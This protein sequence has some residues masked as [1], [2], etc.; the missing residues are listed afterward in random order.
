MTLSSSTV[1]VPSWMVVTVGTAIGSLLLLLFLEKKTKRTQHRSASS[2]SINN[3]PYLQEKRQRLP[4]LILLLRHAESE[5]NADHTIFRTKPDNLVSLTEK[6]VQ[7]AIEAGQRI[8]RLFQS[9]ENEMQTAPIGLGRES[10]QK[11]NRVHIHVS[12]YERTVQTVNA[13]RQAFERRVVRTSPESRIREQEFGNYSLKDS[14]Q[15]QQEQQQVGR[16]WYR[17]PTGESG[18]DVY[19]R[20]KSW[21]CE[22]VLTVNERVGYD[23][24]DAIVVV[25]HSL[26]MRFVLMQL[27]NW[28]PFTFHSVWSAQACELYVLRKDLAIPGI[29]PYILDDIH[30]DMPRS[31]VNVHVRLKKNESVDDT[32]ECTTT[33]SSASTEIS[34]TKMFLLRDYLHLP[35]PR[36]IQT[37]L[38]KERL[39]EQYPQ[40]IN[41]PDDIDSISF[42][43]YVDT[44]DRMDT[45]NE[46]EKNGLQ[47][48]GPKSPTLRSHDS[49]GFT[50]EDHQPLEMSFRWPRTCTFSPSM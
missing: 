4:S 3:D 27:Y 32:V 22:S 25:T 17:F 30:G 29:D 28:S 42:R 14:L 2:S 33:S 34:S 49:H 16:F 39:M 48:V 31:S 1:A 47:S 41:S 24:V 50:D 12:P 13:A 26:S 46:R 5:G 40:E 44:M 35:P 15:Q 45:S 11:I 37:K 36:T 18:A 43:P 6:G 21:W 23:R 9:Y 38:I 20:V 8:E 7:Q 19:D 10:A